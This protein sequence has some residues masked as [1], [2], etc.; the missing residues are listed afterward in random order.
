MVVNIHQQ[1]LLKAEGVRHECTVLKTPEQN[2][3]AERLDRTLVKKTC[4]MLIDLKFQHKFWA[5]ALATET[6]QRNRCPTKALNGMAPIQNMD[7]CE[8]DGEIF[9]LR[10]FCAHAKGRET[11]T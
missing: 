11:Q 6:Y 2:G 10:C 3:V 4:S 8:T 5:E 9:Q 1:N 7:E